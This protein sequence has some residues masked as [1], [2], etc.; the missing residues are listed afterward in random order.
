MTVLSAKDLNL[1]FQYVLNTRLNLLWQHLATWRLPVLGS[2]ELSSAQLPV[3]FSLLLLEPWPVGNM[4]VI[5]ELD[6]GT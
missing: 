6:G 2:T 5:G 4:L 3:Y 1:S